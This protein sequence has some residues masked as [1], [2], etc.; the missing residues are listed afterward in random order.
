MMELTVAIKYLA[1]RTTFFDGKKVAFRVSNSLTIA[2][3]MKKSESLKLSRV[4]EHLYQV[5]HA[6]KGIHHEKELLLGFLNKRPVSEVQQ[7]YLFLG[8]TIP[9]RAWKAYDISS[10][11]S[12]N[13]S[14]E[15]LHDCKPDRRGRSHASCNDPL[16]DKC[17]WLN[18]PLLQ[19]HLLYLYVYHPV[20]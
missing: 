10:C 9:R 19:I 14:S 5:L 4:Y 1:T 6:E 15:G 18:I 17:L 12:K 20:E 8:I 7:Y 13:R 11:P 16:G 3:K 2:P